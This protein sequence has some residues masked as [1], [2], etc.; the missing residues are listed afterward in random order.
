MKYNSIQELV[1]IATR[2]N[3]KISEI[4]IKDQAQQLEMSEEEIFQKMEES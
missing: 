2:E 4:C 1:D 3:K